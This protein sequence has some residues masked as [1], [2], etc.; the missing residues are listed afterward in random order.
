MIKRNLAAQYKRL[1]TLVKVANLV[2]T[3]KIPPGEFGPTRDE[4]L[5]ERVWAAASK[6]LRAGPEGLQLGQMG[7]EIDYSMMPRVAGYINDVLRH[8]VQMVQEGR[9]NFELPEEPASVTLWH[10][11]DGRLV[12]VHFDILGAAILPALASKSEVDPKRDYV[13]AGRLRIC[14]LCSLL[15]V[16]QRTDSPACSARCR[17]AW[18]KREFDA[19]K[20]AE[21]LKV[22]KQIIVQQRE[23]QSK[24]GKR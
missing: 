23:A 20:R 4:A 2:T 6:I 16:A 10:L 14:P 3:C 24:G 1:T 11:P 13:D 5:L 12:A 21:Y 15:F 8:V 22:Y 18:N 17:S 9:E 7:A 19:R